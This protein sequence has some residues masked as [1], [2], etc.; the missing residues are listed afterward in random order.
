VAGLLKKWRAEVREETRQ[1]WIEAK[2][3]KDKARELARTRLRARFE[4]RVGFSPIVWSLIIQLALQ[5]ILEWYNSKNSEPVAAC[6][7]VDALDDDGLDDDPF[8]DG[9]DVPMEPDSLC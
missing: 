6:D 7:F 1:C 9:D 3:D 8:G 4:G 2:G 5:L